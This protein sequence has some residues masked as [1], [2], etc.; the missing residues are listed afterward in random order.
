MR[1]LAE[2]QSA[3]LCSIRDSKIMDFF[4][5]QH[6]DE[7]VND[8]ANAYASIGWRFFCALMMK[9]EFC[10][11]WIILIKY[12]ITSHSFSVLVNGQSEG[13]WIK[14]Q[15]G[16][17]QG[18]PLAP[19]LFV[20]AVDALAI[21]I[22]QECSHGR[23]QGFQTTNYPSGIPMLQ[24]ADDTTFFMEGSMEATKNLSRLLDQLAD[25][26]VLQIN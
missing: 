8:F 3:G 14:Q 4:G 20:L 6:S 24:Y 22:T 12:C 7:G 23:L 5:R 19:L 11:E 10:A 17:R 13:G 9:L 16:V 1:Q 18:C 25:V 21:Y 26:S 15:K 2:T